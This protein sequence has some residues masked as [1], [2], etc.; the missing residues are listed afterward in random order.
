[1][2]TPKSQTSAASD[3]I[4]G[5]WRRW[6]TSRGEI[7]PIKLFSSGTGQRMDKWNTVAAP[8][9][10]L[11][12]LLPTMAVESGKLRGGEPRRACEVGRT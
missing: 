1:M 9:K 7:Q 4:L 11:T 5:F 12:C 10:M 2:N 3:S 8:G 6:R